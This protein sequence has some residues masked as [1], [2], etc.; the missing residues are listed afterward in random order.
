MKKFFI[1]KIVFISSRSGSIT[2]RGTLPHHKP[3]G[4]YIYRS[5]KAALNAIT[6]S[7]SYDLTRQGFCVIVLHPGF[8]KTEMAIGDTKLDVSTSIAGMKKIIAESTPNDNGLFRTFE[9]EK[10]FW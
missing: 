4:P 6:Q 2:E 1:K 5:S 7:L 3:G 9:G 8:V 10:I